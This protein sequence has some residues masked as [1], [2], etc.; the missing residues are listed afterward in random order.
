SNEATLLVTDNTPP[1][2]AV[3]SPTGRSRIPVSASQQVIWTAT[4]NIRVCKAMASLEYSNNGG[5]AWFA[6][7]PSGG[8]PFTVDQSASCNAPGLGPAESQVT[9]TVPST[10]PSGQ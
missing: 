8:L 4:D 3:Q 9:Y 1:V 10:F 5:G 6:A 7:A 2:V